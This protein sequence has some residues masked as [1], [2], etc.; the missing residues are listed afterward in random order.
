MNKTT[1]TWR[2]VF[3]SHL[4]SVWIGTHRVLSSQ[5]N[6]ARYDH[7]EDGHL[8]ITQSDHIVADPS[9]T[10]DRWMGA[11]T[12]LVDKCPYKEHKQK[13]GT[14]KNRVLINLEAFVDTYGLEA[15]KMNMLSGA[16]GLGGIGG[17]SSSVS[18]SFSLSLSDWYASN[19]LLFTEPQTEVQKEREKIVLAVH[20][21]RC[22]RKN[23]VSHQNNRFIKKKDKCKCG[24]LIRCQKHLHMVIQSDADTISHFMIHSKGVWL[25][26]E[27]ITVLPVMGVSSSSGCADISMTT[28]PSRLDLSRLMETRRFSDSMALTVYSVASK[29]GSTGM[30]WHNGSYWSVFLP[31]PCSDQVQSSS[32]SHWGGSGMSAPDTAALKRLLNLTRKKIYTKDLL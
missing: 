9:D 27:V 23:N 25:Q 16:T 15:L 26:W 21:L 12:F 4:V 28:L 19:S 24:T 30:F 5:S 8:K 13:T 2:G 11:Y 10:V 6:A 7:K 1:K 17:S 29:A 20:G 22:Q 32:C 14:E 18:S 31:S 3:G